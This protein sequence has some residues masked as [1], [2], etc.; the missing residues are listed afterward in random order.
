MPCGG[1]RSV[2]SF[3]VVDLS[4]SLNREGW[5]SSAGSDIGGYLKN[6]HPQENPSRCSHLM[7]QGLGFSQPEPDLSITDLPWLSILTSLEL[8]TSKYPVSVSF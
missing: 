2:A 5:A 6:H 3:N 1:N 8:C 4:I 7:F